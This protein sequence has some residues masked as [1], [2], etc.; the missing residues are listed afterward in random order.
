MIRPEP[1]RPALLI[2]ALG[3]GLLGIGRTTGSGWVMVVLAALLAILVVGFVTPLLGLLR[4]R[5][6]L[7]VPAD[8]TVGHPLVLDLDASGTSLPVRVRVPTFDDSERRVEPPVRG[9]IRVAARRRGVVDRLAVTVRCGAPLGLVTWRRVITVK[10]Q[11]PLEVGPAPLDAPPPPPA[12]AVLAGEASTANR[13]GGDVV[14]TVREYQPGDPARHV[15]WPA[16][17][18]HGTLMVR[19]LEEPDAPA[20]AIVVDLTPPPTHA[21]Q[22]RGFDDEIEDTARRAAGMALAALREGRRVHLLT[23]EEGGGRAGPVAT[24]IEL[25]RRLARAVPGPPADGPLPAGIRVA[26]VRVTA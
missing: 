12:T 3:G 6:Q 24:P 19:E 16:T 11:R 26:R 18:R 15:H 4:L 14:R 10:L 23:A 2:L 13:L 25:G 8:A 5:L 9:G 1:S 7:A 22:W 17:A 21:F 20:L